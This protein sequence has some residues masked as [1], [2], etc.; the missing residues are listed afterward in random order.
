MS[1][2][3]KPG[4]PFSPLY[5]ESRHLTL[6]VVSPT[7]LGSRS[8]S[9]DHHRGSIGNVIVHPPDILIIHPQASMAD[10]ESNS[11]IVV[12]VRIHRPVLQPG[13]EA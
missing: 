2:R 9:I 13:V 5:I 3:C 7:F 6:L 8:P 4:G 1:P 10:R 11:G 12:P